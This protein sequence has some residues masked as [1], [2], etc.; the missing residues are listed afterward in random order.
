MSLDDLIWISI[1]DL[2]CIMSLDGL[3]HSLGGGYSNAQK[4][5]PNCNSRYKTFT[6]S[7]TDSRRFFHCS[8]VCPSFEPHIPCNRNTNYFK[9]KMRRRRKKFETYKKTRHRSTKK[10]T[11]FHQWYSFDWTFSSLQWYRQKKNHFGRYHF[12][13][14]FSSKLLV[15][16]WA[17]QYGE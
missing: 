8:F 9:K 17:L 15:P 1:D 7:R 2:I 11:I 16:R 6:L 3:F 12:H 13:W 14:T 10:N 4:P 5:S